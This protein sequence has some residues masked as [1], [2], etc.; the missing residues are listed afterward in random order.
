MLGFYALNNIAHSP[1][2]ESKFDK[3]DLAN[4]NKFIHRNMSPTCFKHLKVFFACQDPTLPILS[5]KE[6]GNWFTK[7]LVDW[8]NHIGP[9]VW[10]LGPNAS[11]DEQAAVLHS[12]EGLV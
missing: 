4:G 12:K 1:S 8:I 2:I 10:M 5:K 3:S 9:L 6:H 11:V 7:P